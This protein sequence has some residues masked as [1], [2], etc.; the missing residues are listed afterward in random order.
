MTLKYTRQSYHAASDDRTTEGSP[1]VM[2]PFDVP[3][4]PLE[5]LHESGVLGS[6]AATLAER[7]LQRAAAHG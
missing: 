5:T 3:V 4:V 7:L 2:T 1:L 6:A